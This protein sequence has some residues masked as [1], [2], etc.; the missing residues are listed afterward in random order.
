MELRLTTVCATK[1]GDG[2]TL[3]VYFVDPVAS[4]QEAVCTCLEFVFFQSTGSHFQ[5][6]SSESSTG[7]VQD[8]VI[9]V[10]KVHD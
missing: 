10:P 5:V 2:K 4:G 9:V 7:K 3:R 6:A 8:Y 1:E